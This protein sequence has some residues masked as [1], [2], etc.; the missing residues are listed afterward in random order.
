MANRPINGPAEKCLDCWHYKK[1]IFGGPWR[2]K[3]GLF[4]SMARDSKDPNKGWA[5]CIAY[6]DLA[7]KDAPAHRA[8]IRS[9]RRLLG[10]SPKVVEDKK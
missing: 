10:Y 6:V 2:C 4:P 1:G 9:F 3:F 8:L 7:D 5:I